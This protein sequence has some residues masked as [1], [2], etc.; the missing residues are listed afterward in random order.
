MFNE[1]SN[2]LVC[3][4]K[5]THLIFYFLLT[6]RNLDIMSVQGVCILS[7]EWKHFF[8]ILAACNTYFLM[9]SLKII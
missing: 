1:L 9:F 5:L 7:S 4:F 2:D 8:A 6:F 3:L